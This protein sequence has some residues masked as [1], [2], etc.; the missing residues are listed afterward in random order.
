MYNERCSI[1]LDI[2]VA[3]LFLWGSSVPCDIWLQSLSQSL[4]HS[5]NQPDSQ[6]QQYKQNLKSQ[7]PVLYFLDLSLGLE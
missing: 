6:L 3:M 7:V 2:V 4:P 5:S 1:P